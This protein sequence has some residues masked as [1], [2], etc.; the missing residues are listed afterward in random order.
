MEVES[1]TTKEPNYLV[2]LNLGSAPLLSSIV[3]TGTEDSFE[4]Y[5]FNPSIKN[6]RG[7]AS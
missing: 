2:I 7:V 3:S 6:L 4:N 1:I 5:C